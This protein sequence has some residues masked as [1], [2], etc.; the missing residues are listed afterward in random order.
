MT[1]Q[2]TAEILYESEL[3]SLRAELVENR[4]LRS[5][6]QK[7]EEWERSSANMEEK[8]RSELAAA[9]EEI[10]RLRKLIVGYGGWFKAL[11]GHRDH[12]NNEQPC[13]PC[14]LVAESDSIH[15]HR[16]ALKPEPESR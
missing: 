4:E 14:R 15:A 6:L 9:K 8:L 2:T 16:A 5:K 1:D 7:A 13:E 10:E 11:G 12:L 3:A